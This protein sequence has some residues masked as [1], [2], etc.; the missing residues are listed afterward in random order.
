ML[1]IL[2]FKGFFQTY[3]KEGDQ[4]FK[5]TMKKRNII[6]YIIRFIFI[7]G[8][9][10]VTGEQ[11]S[12]APSKKDVRLRKKRAVLVDFSL[13]EREKLPYELTYQELNEK[14]NQYLV[15][16]NKE[17]AVKIIEQMLRLCADMSTLA[18]LILELADILY[19]DS[20][21]EASLTAYKNFM[22]HY[23][24]HQKFEYA[25][26]RAIQC[27]S[28]LVLHFDR[29]QTKTEETI[30]LAETYLA[31][32][33]CVTYRQEVERIKNDSLAHLFASELYTIEFY[34][35][36]GK[37]AVAQKRLHEIKDHVLFKHLQNYNEEIEK[38][39]NTYALSD[40]YPRVDSTSSVI[41]SVPTGSDDDLA[42]I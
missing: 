36:T 4:M 28:R 22:E 11:S 34:A 6:W 16:Q 5:G 7:F 35:R 18:E 21:F 13:Q 41:L 3:G 39:Q 24:G 29:D 37:I 31:E 8:H 17:G 10:A 12:V 42:D 27:S 33:D 26:F 9:C 19:D 15:S 2:I 38:I 32:E 23:A 40:Y 14:K 1:S 20:K 30:A 25:L